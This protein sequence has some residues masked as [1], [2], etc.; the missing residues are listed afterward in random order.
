MLPHECAVSFNLLGRNPKH[1][2][3][4]LAERLIAAQLELEV[5]SPD[6]IN[7][8]DRECRDT[9]SHRMHEIGTRMGKPRFC[10]V[11]LD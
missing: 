8:R 6:V 10:S 7:G 2:C 11:L 3:H 4:P 1:I 5:R 9:A